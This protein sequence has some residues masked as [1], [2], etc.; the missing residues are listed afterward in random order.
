MKVLL[1]LLL[2][3]AGCASERNFSGQ[4]TQGGAGVNAFPEKYRE[5]ILAY[6][7]SYLNDPTGFW[8]ICDAN[9]TPVA[10]SLEAR[11]LIGIPAVG[12]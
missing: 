12:S 11:A 7:R 10:G 3:L 6:Q 8:R 1:L 5:E 2:L 9:N 4:E